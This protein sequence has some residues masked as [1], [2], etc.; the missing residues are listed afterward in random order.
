M[1]GYHYTRAQLSAMPDPENAHARRGAVFTFDSTALL[2][3]VTLLRAPLTPST[4]T[5]YAPS[6]DHAIKDPVENDIPIPP[7]SRILVFE[8]NYLSLAKGEWKEITEMMDELWFVEVEDEVAGQRLVPRHV[9]AGIARDE[10]EARKRVWEND[11]VNG[12]EIVDGR[13][14]VTEVVVS[15]E[16]EGWK[17]KA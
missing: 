13:V 14:E 7:T 6:F 10:E 17:P 11:L 8:G 1:D 12:R 5:Y 2:S 3:L 16:D 9:K 4:P 15:K